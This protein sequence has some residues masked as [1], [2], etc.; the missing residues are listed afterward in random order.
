MSGRKDVFLAA[1]GIL[2]GMALVGPAA[3]AVAA[4]TAVPSTQTFC[5]DGVQV[6]LE[7][8]VINGHNYV[9]LRD[10]GR[11]ADFSVEYDQAANRV[12]VDS[13]SPYQEEVISDASGAVT[14][15]QTDEPFRPLAGEVLL[16]EDGSTFSITRAKPEE[17]P[18]PEPT[19]DWSRLPVPELPEAVARRGNSGVVMVTNLYE[20]RRMQYTIY[21]CVP[22][23]PELWESGALKYS[24]GGTPLLRLSLGITE[25]GGIQPFWPWR[26]EQLTQVFC[27]APMAR[28]ALSAWDYYNSEG[29]F[30]YTRY[31]IQG[32]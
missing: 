9:Q 19:W 13:G 32:R 7:A 11:A 18:L 2:A 5:V 28:F 31:S 20:L 12:L 29:Q 25:E 8:Y 15:P 26:A 16:L 10:I 22:D 6:D 24:A 21:N 17:P 30:M 27:S 3:A 4:I 23:C 1:A 14:I